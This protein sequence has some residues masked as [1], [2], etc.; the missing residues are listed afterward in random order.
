M[1]HNIDS[2]GRIGA[3]RAEALGLL[4]GETKMFCPL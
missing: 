1:A 3:K 4:R 2:E